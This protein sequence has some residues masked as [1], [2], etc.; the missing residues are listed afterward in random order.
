MEDIS[1]FYELCSEESQKVIGERVI[2]SLYRFCKTLTKCYGIIPKEPY[3]LV[4]VKWRTILKLKNEIMVE[5]SSQ[6]FGI[7][8]KVAR[9]MIVDT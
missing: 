8:K 2:L 7:N 5:A 9:I 6:D 1:K 3:K 4:D